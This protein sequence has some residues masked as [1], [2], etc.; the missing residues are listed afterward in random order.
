MQP[1]VLMISSNP[2]HLSSFISD[3]CL[4]F[5]A[6]QVMISLAA[7]TGK[8]E[9]TSQIAFLFL[10]S[11]FVEPRY[12]SGG[13]KTEAAEQQLT[14]YSW[15]L[16]FF[17]NNWTLAQGYHGNIG[18]FNGQRR[19]LWWNLFRITVIIIDPPRMVR[20]FC[21]LWNLHQG[22]PSIFLFPFIN[23]R[24]QANNCPPSSSSLFCGWISDSVPVCGIKCRRPKWSH[25]Q[26]PCMI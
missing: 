16:F 15:N 13:M 6:A 23:A 17:F 22:C 4:L 5:L 21:I 11:T 26:V 19:C 1:F 14:K 8:M 20:Q 2:L 25:I 12:S 9:F 10:F 7:W 18:Q 24:R 3:K